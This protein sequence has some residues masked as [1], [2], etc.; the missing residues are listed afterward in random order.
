MCSM[1]L[2]YLD[3]GNATL[4]NLSISTL[5]PLQSILNY[6]AKVTGKKGNMTALLNAHQHFTG[7][8]YTTDVFTKS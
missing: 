1:V 7:Y 2:S 4:V 3:Y 6:A 8:Q 5:K